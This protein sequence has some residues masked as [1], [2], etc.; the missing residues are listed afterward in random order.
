[1][2]RRIVVAPAVP[3]LLERKTG[4]FD[5]RLELHQPMVILSLLTLMRVPAPAFGTAIQGP[6]WWWLGGFAGVTYLTAAL[7]LTPK[8]GASGFI[9]AVIAGQMLVSVLIDHFGLMGLTAKPANIW[10]IAGMG[11]I[12]AGMVLV[13]KA[14]SLS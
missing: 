6:A 3:G 4:K 11:L 14:P 2:V 9:V 7:I 10:R 1:V 13:Q 5:W 12:L 8:L